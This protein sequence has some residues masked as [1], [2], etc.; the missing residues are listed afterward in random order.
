MANP[1]VI[2]RDGAQTRD[3]THIDDIYRV[4]EQLLTD[5]Q[6]DGEILNV[7]S[8]A[9]IDIETL[10]EVVRDASDP[11]L[12]LTHT[13]ARAGDAEHTRADCITAATLVGDAPTID[14]RVGVQ[15]VIAWDQANE[16]WY[17]LLVWES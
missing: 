10:A 2:Y 7:G 1:P 9:N 15:R 3:F 8:I 6:A 14:I 11:S 5:N 13:N 16:D 12:A 4:N 17:D